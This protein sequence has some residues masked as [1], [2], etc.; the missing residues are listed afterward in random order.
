L[1]LHVE[2]VSM[3]NI[4]EILLTT[5]IGEIFYSIGFTFIKLSIL[6]LYRHLFPTRFIKVSSMA[7]G[8]FVIMWGI[9]L[10]LVT[11]FSCQ[12][13]H[14]F[15]DITTPSKCVNS[16][17][18][19]I[20]NSIPNI[21]ADVILL[22]LPMRDV[23]RLQLQLRSKIAV[24]VMFV[25]GSFV[26]IA[27]GLRIKFMLS[28]NEDDMTWSYVGVGLWTAVEIDVAV[29]SSCLPTMRPLL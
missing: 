16:K 5:F 8:T 14:G 10:V 21:I 11:I 18:F 24:S 23:W 4:R 15:W 12:P 6:A 17:W 22:F 7:L 19:F 2:R 29:V 25:L 9:S 28:M 1:G 20:G 13:I 3:P 27:S 26:I